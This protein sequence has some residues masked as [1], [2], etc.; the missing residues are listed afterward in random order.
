LLVNDSFFSPPVIE[1]NLGDPL[2]SF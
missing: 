1:P 2:A